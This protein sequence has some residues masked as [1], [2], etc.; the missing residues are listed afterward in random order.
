MGRI[1]GSTWGAPTS[2]RAIERDAH[3]ATTIPKQRTIAALTMRGTKSSDHAQARLASA[4]RFRGVSG[5]SIARPPSEKR[6]RRGRE[7]SAA[8]YTRNRGTRTVSRPIRATAHRH[9]ERSE[10]A[11]TRA[12]GVT[13]SSPPSL[14]AQRSN[15][16]GHETSPC[17]ARS[18]GRVVRC[19]HS[20]NADGR[21]A[22]E[23]RRD[24]GL[25]RGARNGCF[26]W[27][28]PHP[29]SLRF[30]LRSS[31]ASGFWIWSAW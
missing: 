11:P 26:R 2:N 1:V 13:T 29:R 22:S 16:A 6:S 15:A 4:S 21:G 10:A 9:C 8:I 5:L 23:R 17:T 27:I 3:C 20:G 14:R 19:C 25:L 18:G 24:H 28:C 7:N 31:S 30:D 12:T